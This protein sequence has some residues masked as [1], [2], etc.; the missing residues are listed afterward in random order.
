[1]ENKYTR[2]QKNK[3]KRKEVGDIF[4]S[5]V[6]LVLLAL[7]LYML[8]GIDRTSYSTEAYTVR[9]GD[10]LDSLYYRYGGGNLERWR[11]EMKKAN[12]METS[13]LV[14]GEQIVVLSAK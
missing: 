5:A 11:Y 3:R 2:Q 13:G 10:T 7:T 9:F 12:N 6:L 8:F 1:M 14:A 4:M